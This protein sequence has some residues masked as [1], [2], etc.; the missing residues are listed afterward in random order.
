[1]TT[2]EQVSRLIA[3][4]GL[5]DSAQR[6]ACFDRETGTLAQAITRKD[7]VV[8][9]RQS[10][11]AANRTLFGF[12]VP[13]FGGLFGGEDNEVK[14]IESTVVSSGSNGAYGVTVRL[15]DGSAWTQTED[16]PIAL[17]PRKGDKVKVRR[18]AL[19]SYFLSV[20]GQPGVKVRRVG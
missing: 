1:M 7:L 10:R 16:T 19:G 11:V 8:V 13:N 20:N 4:R 3:C 14:E 5:A 18:R 9:D 6:L 17:P 2:P 15:A 12:A